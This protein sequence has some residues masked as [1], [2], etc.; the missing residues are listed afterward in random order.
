MLLMV[1]FKELLPVE[2]DEYQEIILSWCPLC[3]AVLKD[4]R[5]KT[6]RISQHTAIHKKAGV[7]DTQHRWDSLKET[8]K[9]NRNW[10]AFERPAVRQLDFILS[11]CNSDL[12][13]A[14]E[15]RI[16]M[17]K[18]IRSGKIKSDFINNFLSIY[19]WSFQLK[20]NKFKQILKLSSKFNFNNIMIWILN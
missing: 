1:L 13:A 18:L 8:R 20:K 16:T 7:W 3:F 10:A 6:S 9:K 2:I 15:R 19:L 5:G 12:L 17:K 11:N 4:N 14:A